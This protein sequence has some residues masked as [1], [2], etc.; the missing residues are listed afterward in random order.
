MT[1]QPPTLILITGHPATGKTT[2]ARR[3]AHSLNLPAFCKDDGK[4]IL[5]DTLGTGERDWNKKLG[6]ASFELLYWQAD[7]LFQAG[8]SCIIE[9]NFAS[10]YANMSWQ[11]LQ[12][13]YNF[14]CIQLLC[15]AD[16]ELVLQRYSQRIVDGTRHAGHFDAREST[17]LRDAWTDHP[18][19]W[20]DIKGER[21]A[22]ETTHFGDAE[23]AKL[24][25]QI[26]H[27]LHSD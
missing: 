18:A 12:A 20:I 17:E 27:L 3:L 22:V 13:K 23:Y 15:S 4:E 26:L 7:V 2:L 25:D 5:F 19:E 6:V 9:A 1:T 24:L 14:R 11:K 16:I 10:Q 8:L 21:I